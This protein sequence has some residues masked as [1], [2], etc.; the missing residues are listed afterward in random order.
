M[1]DIKI[2]LKADADLSGVSSAMDLLNKKASD[3]QA[4]LGKPINIAVEND[5]AINKIKEVGRA[6]EEAKRRVTGAPSS[7]TSDTPEE[8]VNKRKQRQL[9]ELNEEYKKHFSQKR[10][11]NEL[12]L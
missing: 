7:T 1:A 6:D 12:D 8:I 5:D 4:T 10:E 9:R 2:N 11:L 3:L